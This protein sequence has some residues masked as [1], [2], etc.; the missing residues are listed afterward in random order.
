MKGRKRE[1]NGEGG[2]VI[3]APWR[4]LTLSLALAPIS[5]IDSMVIKKS[6]FINLGFY[7]NTREE[8]WRLIT[9]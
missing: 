9:K 4:A 8:E 5:C 2:L 7:N 1:P 6:F 3:V